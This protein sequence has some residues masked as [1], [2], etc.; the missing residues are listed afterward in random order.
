M[1]DT[2]RQRYIPTIGLEVHAQLSTQSKIFAPDRNTFGGEPNEHISVVSLAHPGTLPKLNLGVVERAMKMGL[3]CNSEILRVQI[4]DRKN[5]F[6]PDLPKGYQLTQDN[7]PIC[8][9][10]EVPI[11]TADGERMVQLNR[12]HLEEDA[13]KLIHNE[14][15]ADSLVDFNRAGVPLIEI[16]TEPVLDTPDEAGAFMAQ[17][18]RVVRYLGICDGNMEQGSLRCD[19]NVSVRLAEEETLGAKVEIKN[20]NS[21]KHIAK[22]ISYE[23]DRQ[24][25]LKDAGQE[26]VSETRTFDEAKGKTFGMRSKEALN[27]Y[28]YF[29][30]PD[31]SPLHISDDWFQSVQATMPPLPWEVEA[32]M[33][34]Q[35]QLPTYDAEI[36]ADSRELADF[37]LAVCEQTTEYKVVSN[38]LLGPVKKQLNERG[39]GIKELGLQPHQLAELIGLVTEQTL[40]FSAAAQQVFPELLKREGSS[41][42]EVAEALDVLTTQDESAIDSIICSV[43]E[44]LP[45]KV[46]QYRKG[47][48]GLIGMFMGQVMKRTGGKADPK[49]TKLLLAKRLD[50]I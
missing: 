29:P 18:R 10:G 44:E 38:W 34:D 19:A 32:K 20:M 47:K 9:G 43:L 42:R 50:E 26:I 25:A 37:F 13:G 40:S 16:V 30:D 45:E 46:A 14:K 36:L 33:V 2:L 48:K 3:A 28:R 24:I 6:Y 17:I 15:S 41:A 12:I 5:Y 7:T 23:I 35:Y 31:L 49:T 8:V 27:D 4:F 22:A 21:L 39:V 11:R 1:Q